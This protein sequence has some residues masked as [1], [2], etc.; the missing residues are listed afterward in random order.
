MHRSARPQ[1]RAVLKT[2]SGRGVH[3][4]KSFF[5]TI[6][7]VYSIA[8]PAIIVSPRPFQNRIQPQRPR[9][10]RGAPEER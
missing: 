9:Q 4:A 2:R 6:V 10:A 7:W 1:A 8:G 3:K 5:T